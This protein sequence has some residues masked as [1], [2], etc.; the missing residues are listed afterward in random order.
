MGDEFNCVS[1][2]PPG[3]CD[4][5]MI[6]G[7]GSLSIF[8]SRGGDFSQLFFKV[9]SLPRVDG[10]CAPSTRRDL[11]SG[12]LEG[13]PLLRPIDA[14]VEILIFCVPGS[15]R[16]DLP[17]ALGGSCRRGCSLSDQTRASRIVRTC[18]CL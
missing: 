8:I 4:S 13:R 3:G 10:K 16:T 12:E 5:N 14:L 6:S 1:R 2:N 7:D 17:G 9:F 18:D 15:S 11:R